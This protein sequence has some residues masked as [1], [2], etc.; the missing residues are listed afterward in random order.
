MNMGRLLFFLFSFY[1]MFVL[2][3][4]ILNTTDGIASINLNYDI[5]LMIFVFSVRSKM[6]VGVL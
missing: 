2:F 1:I 6:V 4:L 3:H 5:N